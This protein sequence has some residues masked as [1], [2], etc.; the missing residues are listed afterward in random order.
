MTT[1]DTHI[2]M[3]RVGDTIIHNGKEMTVCEKDITSCDFLG[4]KIFGD[5]YRLGYKSVKKVIL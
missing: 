4:T 5:C 3:I 1:V 2:S